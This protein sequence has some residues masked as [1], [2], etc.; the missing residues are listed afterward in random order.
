VT[1]TARAAQPGPPGQ[2]HAPRDLDDRLLQIVR[3]LDEVADDR[4]DAA[5]GPAAGEHEF[6]NA[7]GV[8]L[9]TT[10]VNGRITFFNDAAE[11]IWG[12]RPELGEEWCGSWRLYWTD[13][14][15]MRHE[16]CPMAVALREG[17]PIR[18]QEA[19]AERPDGT[20]VAFVPYP[21]PLRDPQG[22]IVGAV[23][24]L[25]DVT[26]RRR[27]EEELRAT[28]EALRVSN[29]VKD[30]FL[31]LVSHELR[32]PVTT[33]YGNARLLRQ[34]GARLSE[35]DRR[36]MLDDMAYD[37]A[38]LLGIIE[39][40]L[41][42][43]RMDAGA[44]LEVEPQV[45][46]HV[47]RTSID[48]FQRRETGRPVTLKAEPRDIVVDADRTSIELLMENF[49]SNA[50]KYSPPGTEI[51]VL[52]GGDDAFGAVQVLDR[53][54]GI[55]PGDPD[56]LFAAFYRTEAAKLRANGIGI[57]LAAC[58]RVAEAQGGRVWARARAGGGSVFGVALPLSEDR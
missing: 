6:L 42:L 36:S 55:G 11:Q 30:E 20:R 56:Q 25:V 40:L 7:L 45:L 23:N 13:G 50:D 31:G 10:D 8:A 34:K 12:R 17:R 29:A 35:D 48:A 28:A 37:S 19:I 4:T 51:E 44:Q 14:R 1:L 21:T 53:G 2:P 41:L 38:R 47:V 24:I 32:T 16:E 57:G 18:D 54:M 3:V 52:V 15:P 5:A 26:E 46:A 33:I 39:N 58:R 27:A 49:L 9:Y 43:T 22:Q